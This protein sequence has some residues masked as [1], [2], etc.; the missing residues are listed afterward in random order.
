MSV[1]CGIGCVQSQGRHT[2]ASSQCLGHTHVFRAIQGARREWLL[3]L[4]TSR[5]QGKNVVCAP[6][7]LCVY[8]CLCICFSMHHC[9][10]TYK[11]TY[12][13]NTHIHAHA[14]TF[15]YTLT[16][17]H[18]HNYKH[19]YTETH[20]QAHRHS[21]RLTLTNTCRHTQVCKYIQHTVTSQ[22]H[23]ISPTCIHARLSSLIL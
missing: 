22:R 3:P 16:C 17:T 18:A 5:G 6:C 1:S 7:T 11:H 14:H 8:V 10:H 23:T 13:H 4:H 15:I 19:S 20:R 9:S 2:C 12:D 21:H